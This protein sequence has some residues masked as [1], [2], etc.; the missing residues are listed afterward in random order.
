M[1]SGGWLRVVSLG[2]AGPEWLTPEA[3]DVLHAATDIV[4]YTPYVEA[5][6][7]TVRAVRHASG[8]GVELDRAR[9]ALQMA[10]S[11]ARVAV[12]SG[13]DAGVFGMAAA[14]MEAVEHGDAAWRNL[15]ITVVPGMSALLAAAARIGAPLGHDFCVMSLSDYLKPW[16]IIERRLQA[17]SA[18][19]FV[20]AL[21]NPASKTRREQLD[22][23]LECL[24]QH[25]AA[26]T[27]VMIAKSIG[28][29][30]E[31]IIVTR[32]D[33]VDVAQV[34][35]RTLLIVGSSRTCC[36]PR[37]GKPPLVY[38]PRFYEQAS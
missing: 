11:G 28:R 21:Y 12:V 22:R 9:E 1:T 30:A 6:P 36:I 33:N 37:E 24:R 10:A 3:S 25:R 17:A 38:T 5:V 27:C 23:A 13:G 2:P 31:E 35:M 14:V 4:G 26:E 18:G 34:D 16:E 32:L 20:L 8:N 19:D 29:A 7:A 15:D